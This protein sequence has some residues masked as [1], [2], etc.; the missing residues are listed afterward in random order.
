MTPDEVIN[1]FGSGVKVA[2][3]LGIKTQNVYAWRKKGYVPIHWQ[4]QLS[5]YTN[6]KLEIDPDLP[7]YQQIRTENG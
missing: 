3:F 4:V 7:P 6:G 5:V 1:Y 2:R